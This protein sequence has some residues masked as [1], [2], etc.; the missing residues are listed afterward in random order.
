MTEDIKHPITIAIRRPSKTPSVFVAASFTDPAWEP[1]ELTPELVSSKDASTTE[2]SS[3]RIEEYEFS[4][5]FELPEG[6]HQ[7]KFRLDTDE[8]TWF[9]DEKV[10][11]DMDV[12]SVVTENG[13]SNNLLVVNETSPT[14]QTKDSKS[15]NG[16]SGDTESKEVTKEEKGKDEK[17]EAVE[18][19]PAAAIITDKSDDKEAPVDVVDKAAPAKEEKPDDPVNPVVEKE[20]TGKESDASQEIKDLPSKDEVNASPDETKQDSKGV[21]E[22]KGDDKIAKK[23]ETIKKTEETIPAGTPKVEQVSVVPETVK[24]TADESKAIDSEPLPSITSETVDIPKSADKESEQTPEPVTKVQIED[25]LPESITKPLEEPK[26]LENGLE[27]K[28]ELPEKTD[29][30]ESSDRVEAMKEDTTHNVVTL[31]VAEFGADTEE[32]KKEA[33]EQLDSATAGSESISKPDLVPETTSKAVE[34]PAT[35]ESAVTASKEA[36][37]EE[38]TKGEPLSETIKE[39]AIPDSLDEPTAAEPEATSKEQTKDEPAAEQDVTPKATPEVTEKLASDEVNEPAA[40]PEASQAELIPETVKDEILVNTEEPVST[41]PKAAVNDPEST[42]LPLKE[43]IPDKVVGPVTTENEIKETPAPGSDL[44]SEFVKEAPVDTEASA[45]SEAKAAVEEPKVS[46]MTEG[47]KVAPVPD[48]TTVTEIPVETEEPIDNNTEAATEASKDS[49]VNKERV[50]NEEISPDK[51]PEND[52]TAPDEATGEPEETSHE[53]E[54]PTE[55]S[56]EIVPEPEP[57]PVESK[58][59]EVPGTTETPAADKPESEEVVPATDNTEATLD[60]SND[61]ASTNDVE[62]PSTTNEPEL[63]VEEQKDEPVLE[64]SKE[65]PC[66]KVEESSENVVKD[67][68]QPAPTPDEAKDEL[69]SGDTEPSPELVKPSKDESSTDKAEDIAEKPAG[70][71]TEA[72]TA[73]EEVVSETSKEVEAAAEEPEKDVKESVQAL[74]SA[75]GDVAPDNILEK[76]PET[77]TEEQPVKADGKPTEELLQPAVSM[78]ALEQVKEKA[79]TAVDETPVQKDLDITSEELS[80]DASGLETTEK[81]ANDVPA[82]TS[83]QVDETGLSHISATESKAAFVPESN[84]VSKSQPEVT[85]EEIVQPAETKQETGDIG[86]GIVDPASEPVSESVPEITENQTKDTSAG[87]IQ[88]D[89]E[90]DKASKEPVVSDLAAIE[91]VE[92]VKSQLTSPEVS[93]Q[94]T[95]EAPQDNAATSELPTESNEP[96]V[97]EDSPVTDAPK[98]AS[99]KILE[100]DG[101]KDTE[102]T[103]EK[104]PEHIIEESKTPDEQKI[105]EIEEPKLEKSANDTVPKGETPDFAPIEAESKEADLPSEDAKEE[106]GQTVDEPSDKPAVEVSEGSRELDVSQKPEEVHDELSIVQDVNEE[107][108]AQP[109]AENVVEAPID[110]QK[111]ADVAV[112]D[113][114]P[115]VPKDSDEIHNDVTMAGEELKSE[116]ERS[117]DHVAKVDDKEVKEAVAEEPPTEKETIEAETGPENQDTTPAVVERVAN[118]TPVQEPETTGD[119]APKPENVEEVPKPCDTTEVKNDVLEPTEPTVAPM[120]EEKD[121]T[122]AEVELPDA[123]ASEV[124]TQDTVS[125]LAPK[126]ADQPASSLNDEQAV[127]TSAPAETVT[128]NL[129]KTVASETVPEPTSEVSKEVDEVSQPPT[130][131]TDP[132]PEVHMNEV[133][134]TKE[135]SD[136]QHAEK[137]AQEDEGG[138]KADLP[139]VSV[140]SIQGADLQGKLQSTDTK[141]EFVMDDANLDATQPTEPTTEKGEEPADAPKTNGATIAAALG[142]AAV[143]PAAALLAAQVGKSKATDSKAT[144][145]ETDAPENLQHV[146]TDTVQDQPEADVNGES[147]KDA[148]SLPVPEDPAI[149]KDTSTTDASSENNQADI[150]EN[151]SAPV[152]QVEETSTDKDAQEAVTTGTEPVPITDDESKK[153]T[154]AE[155]SKSPEEPTSSST[156]DADASAVVATTNGTKTNGTKTNGTSD[157]NRP[158]TGNQSVSSFTAQ[159]RDNFLKALWRAIFVNFFG[160]LFGFRRR[161]TTA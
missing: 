61:A 79:D 18:E 161:D 57:A 66:D 114:P 50:T 78:D 60:V 125:A 123:P 132:E 3:T 136:E 82:D 10:E 98:E 84:D 139:G 76:E 62:G 137:V 127:D 142:A 154:A 131:N 96:T 121:V 55:V 15:T 124:E 87:D 146:N 133:E 106:T 105:S 120:Q 32:P 104:V 117:L 53:P 31:P 29:V 126:P 17:V 24:T 102:E 75:E 36:A 28:K 157:E 5:K 90:N 118:E 113:T 81:E 92:S 119:D 14:S 103:S 112:I 35:D 41:D 128:D 44:L 48:T 100:T 27:S 67:V 149:V 68:S 138:S 40:A 108:N 65:T 99:Q 107:M 101:S 147:S 73:S 26:E 11:T 21:S 30:V 54:A 88:P 45:T 143:L 93:E 83:A 111:K 148:R 129:E 74:E 145:P 22:G 155:A 1:V 89:K 37:G 150:T 52:A 20:A 19:A 152:Q 159:R 47:E 85:G 153:T 59:E 135:A 130:T 64:I 116:T 63:A 58:D 12:F 16:T 80:K 51:T 95:S 39:E 160:S 151:K 71:I 46:E 109:Q 6:K 4:K 7:Y 156:A 8:K 42:Q 33:L 38:L 49:E 94:P 141:E 69:T 9:C 134:T 13:I 115:E 56:K 72:D 86:G 70:D 2:D 25:T 34:E 91:G 144:I 77:T 158:P 110:V 97:E 122:T 140:D 43:I 23:E